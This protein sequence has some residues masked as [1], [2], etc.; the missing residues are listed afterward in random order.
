MNTAIESASADK[1]LATLKQ[2]QKR[3]APALEPPFTR[4]S[5]AEENMERLQ[6]V[7]Q[8][9]EISHFKGAFGRRWTSQM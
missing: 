9:Q 3:L 7:F 4:A 5:D 2:M 1:D 6:E 8:A